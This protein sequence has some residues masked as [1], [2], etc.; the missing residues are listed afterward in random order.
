ME[1]VYFFYESDAVRIPFF[2]YDQRLFRLL[3]RK[4]GTWN[5]ACREFIFQRNTSGEQF[6]RYLPGFPCVEVDEQ[7]AAPV[8][9]FGFFSRPWDE[10]AFSTSQNLP[11]ATPV[12]CED[13][14]LPIISSPC[15]QSEKFSDY[16]QNKLETE[17]RFRK[18]SLKT[19]NAYLYYNRL[20]CSKLNKTPE[21]LQTKD[22][23]EFISSL[24]KVK[25]YSASSMN[26]AISAIK[27]FYKNV[28]P[29]E[30]IKE[31]S[32]PRHDKILPM[33]LDKTEIHTIISMER[34]VKH[35]LLLMLAYSSGLRV[36]EVVALK[37]E[38]IDLPRRVIHI[39]L[40]KGRKDRHT[41]LSEKAAQLIHEY[42]MLYNIQNWLFPGQPSSRHLSIRSA[43]HIFEN[44]VR[45]AKIPKKGTSKNPRLLLFHTG[46][47]C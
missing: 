24:E 37:R 36:S 13:S 44:A 8:K 47:R 2:D 3:A 32:R 46:E 40:G 30:I 4:G 34:N 5:K 14:C 11:G 28:L 35:R 9:V 12:I 21:E 10:E 29:K 19:K 18:Y 6:S 25:K 39:R 45:Y 33:I 38:H 20:V 42:C 31:K 23:T 27:F 41:I 43:Q 17:L 26:L 16:W 7:S 22:I 15:L 1:V